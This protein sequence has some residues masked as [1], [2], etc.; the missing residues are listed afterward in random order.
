MA[1]GRICIVKLKKQVGG[2]VPV[3]SKYFFLLLHCMTSNSVYDELT[4]RDSYHGSKM[5]KVSL[6]TWVEGIEEYGI[7]YLVCWVIRERMVVVLR[8]A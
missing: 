7:K 2:D 5:Q 6:L 4:Q 8:T 3:C 1:S